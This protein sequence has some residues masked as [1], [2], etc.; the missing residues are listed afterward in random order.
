MGVSR[1]FMKTK[2]SVAVIMGSESDFKV[3]ENAVSLLKK[4]KIATE[5]EIVSAHRSPEWMYEYSRKAKSRGLKV[6]IAAAGGAAHLPGMVASLTELPVIGVP[7]NVTS[8]NGMDALMSIV[9]MPRGVP[10]AT[11]AIDNSENAALLAV[12][13]LALSDEKL[14]KSLDK[15]HLSLEKKV[16]TMRG[17]LKNKLS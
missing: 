3:M 7:I 8:L 1:T 5:C 15:F 12:K 14:Q 2:A 9:Q 13:I 10:V 16:E 4:F 11:V 6:I 17:N